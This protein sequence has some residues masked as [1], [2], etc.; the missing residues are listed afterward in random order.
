[1]SHL[2]WII[3]TTVI[4]SV[5][6]QAKELT[7]RL[8][9]GPKLPFSIDLPA[10][11]VH[12][13]PNVDFAVTGALGINT[14]QN[15]S[16]FGLQGGIRRILFEEKNMNFFVG[17][18]LGIISQEISGNNQSGF[19]L[20]ALSGGEFFFEGLENLGFNFEMGVGVASLKSSNSFF[21]VANTPMRAGLV[22]YF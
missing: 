12:Y 20:S 1:M 5:H 4:A 22:F 19:E 2:F 9:V 14:R 18:T 17:G 13:Y 21:T 6:L 7:H 11:A 10:V 8:G 3:V 15:F 16:Q